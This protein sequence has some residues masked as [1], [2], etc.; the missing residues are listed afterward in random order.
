MDSN[1][2][3]TSA[4][5]KFKESVGHFT[6]ELK[7]IRTGRANPSML[8][9]VVVEAY[10]TT[11]PLKQ[12]AN[13]VA[14]EAQLLQVTPF[15]PTNIATIVESIRNNSSLGLNPSDDGRVIRLPIPP[16]TEERRRE[17]S[18]QISEKAEECL[19]RMR[20]VRH[21]ALNA[22][23]QLKK[24]KSIGEDEAS[25]QHKKIEE[26]MAESR[27]EVEDKV[28]QKESEILTL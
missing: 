18:K 6:E 16:L 5:E 1:R 21:D 4:V 20:N 3:V 12:L 27:K 14:I 24:D 17:M 26:L 28:K 19:V 9:G 22:I 15:D 23:D 13:V 7:T 10:G 2:I 8:D 11:M 25:R